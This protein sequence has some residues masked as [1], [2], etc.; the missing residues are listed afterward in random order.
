[1]NSNNTVCTPN[2]H[3]TL[4]LCTAISM[5]LC[6][7]SHYTTPT[8]GGMFSLELYGYHV[9]REGSNSGWYGQPPALAGG[10]PLRAGYIKS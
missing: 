2:V 7:G 5:I 10:G 9:K 1:M 4:L 3:L 6:I 8:T